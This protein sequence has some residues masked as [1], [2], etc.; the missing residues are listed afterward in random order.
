MALQLIWKFCKW[1]QPRLQPLELQLVADSYIK[2]L[3]SRFCNWLQPRLQPPELQLSSC[4]AIFNDMLDIGFSEP[5]ETILQIIKKQKQRKK[6]EDDD[7]Y[8]IF[9]FSDTISDWLKL[10]AAKYLKE[11]YKDI[12]LNEEF[13]EPLRTENN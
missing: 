4:S 12:D 11:N 3:C 9:L 1:L 6:V 8:Q 13:E 5:M 7:D 10:I 2:I